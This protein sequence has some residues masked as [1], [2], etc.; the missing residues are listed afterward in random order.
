MKTSTGTGVS[1]PN[2]SSP[3]TYVAVYCDGTNVVAAGAAGGG[4]VT[5]TGTL[6][7]HFVVLGNGTGDIKVVAAIGTA[8]QVLT[9]NGAGVDP[10]FQTPSGGTLASDTDV[11][12]TAP[13]NGDLLTYDSGA[14]KWENKPPLTEAFAA[15]VGDGVSTT[16][17]VTHNL[18]TLDV[19]VEVHDIGT[20]AEE[21]ATTT[22]TVTGV[23][24]VDVT[25]A[26]PPAS[27]SKRAIIL[28]VGGTS[29]A[30]LAGLADV[31]ITSPTTGQELVYNS[32]SG[33][34]ENQ[35]VTSG[36]PTGT[37]VMS[38]GYQGSIA[39]GALGTGQSLWHKIPGRAL[40]CLPTS[41]KVRI[42]R[43]S[44]SHFSAIVILRTAIDS[45]TVIDSTPVLF[46]GSATPTMS[47]GY[48]LS[49]A[50]S[51]ALDSLHDYWIVGFND[52]G[53]SSFWG[54]KP[55]VQDGTGTIGIVGGYQTGDQTGVGTIPIGSISTGFGDPWDAA[56]AA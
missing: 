48:N 50:I 27:N 23:N 45:Q 3:E 14:G 44:G 35:T 31:A 25:F 30:T 56:L 18:N 39:L 1:L 52:S 17:T 53:D 12:I 29:A 54:F 47:A 42:Q 26:A 43:G 9:S 20:G 55:A 16:I 7:A 38:M 28:A 33:K 46:G 22:Y 15:S 49:D 36:I 19:S 41:W 5:H 8:G 2:S 51:L 24:T 13:A 40:H 21:P 34:W 32:G 10:S 11:S 37:P 4:T 6:T